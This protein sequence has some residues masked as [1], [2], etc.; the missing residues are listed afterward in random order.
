MSKA[1]FTVITGPFTLLSNFSIGSKSLV[2]EFCV[3]VLQNQ[4]V[5][6]TFTPS[7]NTPYAFINGIEIVSTPTS[8]YYSQ[9]GDKVH[10]L[11]AITLSSISKTIVVLT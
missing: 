11:S 5:N 10:V 6:I 8:L 2:K 4:T 1:L 3:N 7:I 9:F